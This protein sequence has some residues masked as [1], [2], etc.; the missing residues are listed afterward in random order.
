MRST[1]PVV[2]FFLAAA[3]RLAPGQDKYKDVTASAEERAADLVSRMTLEE[4]VSQMQNNAPAIPRLGIPAYEWW[5]EA[6]HGV[7]RAGLATVFPQAIGLAATWDKN[8]EHNIADTISTEARAKY[9]DAIAH[10]NHNR[11]YGLTFWSPNIN[12]FRDPRWGRGQETYGED[13]YLTSQMAIQFIKGMQGN[14][15][16]YYKTIATS[17]HYAV[18]SGPELLRHGFNVNVTEDELNNTYL[19]AFRQTVEQAHVDS[20]MCVYNAVDGVPGCANQFL[21]QKTLRDAWKFKGYVVS[22]CDSVDDIYTGHHYTKTL[23]EAAAL[24]VK[25]GTDLD[26]G[27][28]YN[29]LTTAVQQGLLTEAEINRSVVRLFTARFQLGMFDPPEKVPFSKLGMDVVGSPEHLR[30][31][32]Q[33]ARESIVLLKNDH[34]FLPLTKVPRRIAIVGPAADDPDAM[35]GNYNGIPSHIGT[36]LTGIEKEFGNRAKVDF[37]LG[38]SYVAGWSALVPQNVLTPAAESG[39]QGLKAE[40]FSVEDFSGSATLSR[41]EPRVFFSWE[42]QDPAI[43]KAVTRDRFAIRWTGYLHP[44]ASG[45]YQLGAIRPECHSCGRVDAARLYIDDQLLTNDAKQAGEQMY[46]KTTAIRLETG[47]T[48]KIRIEYTQHGGGGGLQL[49]WTPPADAALE[50]AVNLV[51]SADVAIACVGL[52]SRL[53]GEESPLKIP[54]FAGGDRTDVRLP[55]SQRNLLDA[56]FKT[57]KPVVVVLVNGS[58]LAIPEA[59]QNAKAILETWYG[60][61]EAGT[62]LAETLAGK[63]NPGGR[64]PVTFYASVDD[65]PD[66]KD[67][68]MKNRTYRFFTGTPLYPFGYGL[69]YS[70]F[71]YSKAKLQPGGD[72]TQLHTTVQNKSARDGD[73]VVEVYL[74]RA[75]GSNPELRGFERVHLKGG[76]SR[77]VEFS[78][79]NSE[80][81]GRVISIGQPALLKVQP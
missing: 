78:L 44:K 8:L 55:E 59:Q 39:V 10:G 76:E 54:G 23:A 29:Q 73:E 56:L 14:D 50:E 57:G 26:C 37:A 11:Y 75:D 48:Y 65:L 64:L 60:G 47:K 24:A 15:P 33:A 35:L 9:N 53:E 42:T 12:I 5:N 20:F 68:S 40:Y 70:H 1:I 4:K 62:A 30:I 7:A 58:A 25:A 81:Q 36:P 63:N 2:L 18:H 66:F 13:P 77:N 46:S 80:L 31:S 49:V 69:S 19:Y 16:H 38:S 71:V 51:K 41:T 79:D 74:T 17:K 32:L 61:Q 52:N 72:T 6:L 43:L 27:K 3:A 45:E 22:D 21:L 34:D 67:Y 28:S